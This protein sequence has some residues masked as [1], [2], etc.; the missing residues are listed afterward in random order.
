MRLA[1]FGLGHACGVD[2][3]DPLAAAQHGDAVG[4]GEHFVELVADED[5]GL[6][7]G[8]HLAQGVEEGFG[9][10]RR[11]DGGRLVEDQNV[12]LHGRAA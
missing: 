2:G 11:E 8:R 7:V 10:L 5:D 6:A 1:Q 3:V 9:F 12:A 4:D